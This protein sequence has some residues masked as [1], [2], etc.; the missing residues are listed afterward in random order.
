MK[1]RNV[2]VECAKRWLGATTGDAAHKEIVD[3]YNSQKIL[4]RGYKVKYTD[5]WCATFVS[6]VAIACGYTDIIPTECGCQ[7]MIDIYSVMG[8]F[9][10]SV[11]PAPGDIIFYDW[12]IDGWSDHVG[13][14]VAVDGEVL[15]VIEGNYLNQVKMRGIRYDDKCISGYGLPAYDVVS[16]DD[17]KALITKAVKLI[18]E[19][20]IILEDMT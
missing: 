3:I 16:D 6:A 8:R 15:T 18:E 19:A 4:P 5:N 9:K 2:V 1:S 14:V 12:K 13:I 17:S 20:L 7:K 11:I 10:K